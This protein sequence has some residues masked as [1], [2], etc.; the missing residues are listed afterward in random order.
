MKNHNHLTKK[1]DFEVFTS[2]VG[3]EIA[4]AQV[5]QIVAANAQTLVHS[6]KLENF[7]T[8]HQKG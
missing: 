1:K 3:F 6:W 7:I 5:K 8:Y 2:A 4:H